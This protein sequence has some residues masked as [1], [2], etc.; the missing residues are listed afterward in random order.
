MKNGSFRRQSIIRRYDAKMTRIFLILSADSLFSG[1]GLQMN[2]VS[3]SLGAVCICTMLNAS[4]ANFAPVADTALLSSRPTN[5]VNSITNSLQIFKNR[6]KRQNTKPHRSSGETS[7]S[8]IGTHINNK[9]ISGIAALH[10]LQNLLNRDRNVRLP[11][12]LS[13]KHPDDVLVGLIGQVPQIRDRKQKRVSNAFHDVGNYRGAIIVGNEKWGLMVKVGADRSIGLEFPKRKK[14]R[15]RMEKEK[16]KKR[17]MGE[18]NLGDLSLFQAFAMETSTRDQTK[19]IVSNSGER[20]N[21][22]KHE[23]SK[24]LYINFSLN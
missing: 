15:M 2:L 4:M 19:K 7:H 11:K 1:H 10:L 24:V 5:W 9:S 6:L 3:S 22:R 18:R 13:L 23:E 14:K 17:K 12:G 16:R 20:V 21:C 8:N